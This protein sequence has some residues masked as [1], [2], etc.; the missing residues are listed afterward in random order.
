MRTIEQYQQK[1][2]GMRP[3]VYMG[4]E[5]VGRDDPR[6]IPGIKTIGMTFDL[7]MDPEQQDLTTAISHLTGERINAR[8]YHSSRLGM[9]VESVKRLFHVNILTPGWTAY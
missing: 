1:L 5:L 8:S 6:F 3:N 7:A 2:L 4:G 9:V